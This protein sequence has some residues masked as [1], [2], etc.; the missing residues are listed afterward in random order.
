MEEILQLIVNNGLGVAS[1]FCLIYFY[2]NFVN[3]INDT[4][5][6]ICNTLESIERSLSDLTLRVDRIEKTNKP[7]KF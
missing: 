1:F 3:K 5:Q 7:D 4:N 2:L 6:K